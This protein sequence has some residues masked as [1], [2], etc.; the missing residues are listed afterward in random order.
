MREGRRIA[1]LYLRDG[2]VRSVDRQGEDVFDVPREAARR[3]WDEHEL[4]HLVFERGEEEGMRL[5]EMYL[6]DG[7]DSLVVFQGGVL[8]VEPQPLVLHLDE[9][10][11][12]AEVSQV[13]VSPEP[14]KSIRVLFRHGRGLGVRE[15][16]EGWSL[17]E[18]H[19]CTFGRKE[20]KAGSGGYFTTFGGK[21]LDLEV[22]VQTLRLVD[23]SEVVFHCRLRGGGFG[24][25]GKGGCPPGTGEWTCSN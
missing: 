2:N 18:W 12:V 23:M 8:E 17:G 19:A 3:G 6:G 14:A 1:E 20:E 16:A 22:E 11:P 15:L 7:D 25:M 9:L 5:E 24:G 21:I 13:V 10:I 4:M